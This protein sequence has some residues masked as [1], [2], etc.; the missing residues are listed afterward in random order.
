[1]AQLYNTLCNED[2]RTVVAESLSVAHIP[3]IDLRM[4]LITDIIFE[5]LVERITW[6]LC[7]PGLRSLTKEAGMN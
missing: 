3:R 6:M 5:V 4:A 7:V 2:A 1:M